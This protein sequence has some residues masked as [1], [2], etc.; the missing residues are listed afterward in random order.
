MI[1]TQTWVRV[2][3]TVEVSV[4]SWGGDATVDQIF[5]QSS[6]EAV[7]KLRDFFGAT[8]KVRVVGDPKAKVVIASKEDSGG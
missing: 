7:E 3:V 6:K 2:A 4:G 1:K 5:E 8:S